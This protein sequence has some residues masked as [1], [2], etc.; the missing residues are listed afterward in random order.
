[1]YVLWGWLSLVAPYLSVYPLFV[2]RFLRF[3]AEAFCIVRKGPSQAYAAGTGPCAQ[4][5][6]LRK[7]KRG[8]EKER[9]KRE[10]ERERER[11]ID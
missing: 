4:I 1:V 9:G 2:I 7:R 10:I 8:A 6:G 3:C 5:H 11:E